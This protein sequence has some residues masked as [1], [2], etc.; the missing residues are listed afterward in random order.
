[1]ERFIY[2]FLEG[3]I[4]SSLFIGI[5]Y[6]AYFKPKLDIKKIDDA[7]QSNP[8][9]HSIYISSSN[10]E[11]FRKAYFQLTFQKD[12]LLVLM[13]PNPLQVSFVGY[14]FLLVNEKE[15][16]ELTKTLK[17]KLLEFNLINKVKLI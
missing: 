6:F 4:F 7:L 5:V 3:C 15:L 10:V 14:S 13:K 9:G 16:D 2:S 12:K 11:D 17:D 1:M 8:I